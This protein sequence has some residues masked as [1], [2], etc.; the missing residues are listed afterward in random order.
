MSE[1]VTRI[2]DLVI[3]WDT[4]KEQTP[5]ASVARA[6]QERIDRAVASAKWAAAHPQIPCACGRGRFRRGQH[7]ACYQC[8]AEAEEY[9][10]THCVEH[11]EYER[12]T[13][14]TVLC[15]RCWYVWFDSLGYIDGE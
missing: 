15:E 9:A 5:P 13:Q 2:G 1:N 8:R 11:P 7:T 10:R 14:P 4:V 12:V 6:N 3:D